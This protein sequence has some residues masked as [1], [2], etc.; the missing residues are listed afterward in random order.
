MPQFLLALHTWNGALD[1][2][3]HVHA[4]MAAGAYQPPTLR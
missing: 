3:V 2:H 1:F 4:L